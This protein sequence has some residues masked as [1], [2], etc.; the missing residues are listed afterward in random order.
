VPIPQSTSEAIT[1]ALERFDRERR[2]DMGD[3]EANGNFEYAL[4]FDGRRYPPN[5]IISLA[6]GVPTSSFS[7][8]L[9]ANSYLQSMGFPI[10]R[11][12]AEQDDEPAGSPWDAFV[13]WARRFYERPDF[14]TNERNYKLLVADHLL[15]ARHAIEANAGDWF[16]KL[17]FSFGP[18]NNLTPWQVHDRFLRWAADSREKALESLRAAWQSQLLPGD[19]VDAFLSIL[20]SSVVAGPGQRVALASFL[21]AAMNSRE[22]PIYRPDPVR[23]AYKLVRYEPEA[24]TAT[25]GRW[26]QHFLTFLEHFR[27]EAEQRGLQIGDR[28]DAQSLVWTVVHTPPPAD[29]PAV[30]QRALIAYRGGSAH[31]EPDFRSALI[32]I[33]AG[34]RT[35]RD[36]APFSG[37]HPILTAFKRATQELQASSGVAVYPNV[38]VSYSAGQGNWAKVPWIALMD[39]R[40]T[41]T[42]QQ[43]LYCVYLFSEDLSGLFL[44]LNQGVTEPRRELGP[45]AGREFLRAT[46]ASMRARIGGDLSGA[47]FSIDDGINLHS[48]A[49][50]GSDYEASTIAY[51]HYSQDNV[52]GPEQ[53]T[54]DLDVLL[55]VYEEKVVP[56]DQPEVDLAVVAAEFSAALIKARVEFGQRHEELVRTLLSSLLTR[57]L[58]VLTG[59]SGSGKS[60][61]AAK[62]GEWFG[63]SQSLFVP[64]RPDWTG[65]EALF[66]YVDILQPAVSAGRRVWSV[67]DVL[68]F[69][70]RAVRDPGRP[71]VLV[72]DEM[73]LAHVERYF[74]DFL[75][76]MES[77]Q[78]VLPNLVQEGDR[79][80][81]APEDANPLPIPRNLFVIGTVNID[82]TTYMFSPKMLD[83][84]NVLEFRV[85]TQDLINAGKS[86]K[87]APAAEASA[88]ALL[89]VATDDQWHDEHAT[90][91]V[92]A[93]M[94]AMRALHVRLSRHSSE[95]GFRT[96]YDAI[97]YLAIYSA[98]G[99]TSW[100]DCLDLQVVQKVLPRL[101]GS[102]RRLEPLLLDLA[103]F[104]ADLTLE[105]AE[106]GSSLD[107]VLEPNT[108]R[109]LPRTW[110]KL[111][112]MLVSLRADQFA[113]FMQ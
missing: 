112:R 65:P 49:T 53:L 76:G 81:D 5:E 34:Y 24:K 100:I 6:T 40:V 91:D 86:Q 17:R 92:E 54:K 113:S 26:Y 9:E 77:G 82:E 45:K 69:F 42:T 16:E 31:E 98:M 48:S 108:S 103:A 110:E 67:P 38:V 61:I 72:L 32:A 105:G 52:P 12:R 64:V 8:G 41:R 74:A 13:S 88:R 90:Q 87:L 75:S 70:L 21:Q 63:E 15:D 60:Q 84:S 104:C 58:V 57:P 78:P 22:F 79:W 20:P 107:P 39:D 27:V 50:L 59:L 10:V 96:F 2:I 29:W 36:S 111:R 18:P 46:V 99:D 47:G 95:F 25:G 33:L 7:G 68:A 93:F 62:L 23:A 97:R 44:T 106:S 14:A 89:S 3:W 11:L 43:G 1:Q 4:V 101:H 37:G 102:R 94:Q 19:R 28:L 30:D 35:A 56:P 85:A 71:Y 109:Q 55:K 73:N 80:V 83:R 51:K 66:G